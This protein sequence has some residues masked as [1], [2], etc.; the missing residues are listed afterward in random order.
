MMTNYKYCKL[1]RITVDAYSSCLNHALVT[2]SEEVMG[3]LLGNVENGN[4]INIFSTI[5][6]TRKCKQKDRVEFD[7][8]QISQATEI[9]D[10]LEKELKTVVNVVGWYHS[11]PK[12]TIPPSAVDLNTQYSQQYQGPFVGLIISCFSNDNKNT[13][14]INLIAFQTVRENGQNIPL[15]IE[16]DFINERDVF[17]SDK[18]N[19]CNSAVTFSNIIKN[20]LLEEEEQFKKDVEKIDK[21]DFLNN[22]IIS[23]NRQNLISKIIQTISFPYIDSLE[24][25]IENMSNY[26]AYVKEANNILKNRIKNL[27]DVNKIKNI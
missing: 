18:I 13:N 23:S 9:S 15:Y 5:C 20:L 22:V 21:D 4:I 25:E 27:K 3:L 12:I 16:I 17:I 7:E 10:M 8:I 14:K 2:D 24:S 6:M 1:V 26:L 19:V 11:H